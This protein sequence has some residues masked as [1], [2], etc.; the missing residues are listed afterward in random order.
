M[1]VIPVPFL[2][3]WF[4][5]VPTAQGLHDLPPCSAVVVPAS[6]AVELLVAL[7]EG[8]AQDSLASPVVI[9]IV[10]EF[11]HL[12]DV[13]LDGLTDD[14]QLVEAVH[15]LQG[16]VDGL[17]IQ[18][19]VILLKD[20]TRLEPLHNT[21][22]AGSWATG[23][24]ALGNPAEGTRGKRVL[25]RIIREGGVVGVVMAAT[26]GLLGSGAVREMA[27]D[28]AGASRPAGALGKLICR[29]GCLGK[30]ARAIGTD[31][32]HGE[33][34]SWERVR[35]GKDWP[36]RDFLREAA[37]WK[38]GREL[39]ELNSIRLMSEWTEGSAGLRTF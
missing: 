14:V 12:R 13:D 36:G 17:D 2:D 37:G 7:N 20:G 24:A 32:T 5:M 21:G 35:M 11:P 38:S 28:A 31:T 15:K 27:V 10:V 6:V 34:R 1:L 22:L 16:F 26:V 19:E 39:P 29:V 25:E 4:R 9:H 3:P 33:E 30:V 23:V 18:R 8:F